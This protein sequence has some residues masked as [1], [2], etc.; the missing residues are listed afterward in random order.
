[1]DAQAMRAHNAQR[2]L[3]A[4][5]KLGTVSRAE[6]ARATRLS[7]PTVSALVERLLKAGLLEERGEGVSNGGRKP[8][9][10]GFN[11]GCG[12]VVGANIGTSSIQLAVADMNGR[13]LQKR[14]LEGISDVRPRRL[15]RRL[16]AATRR[17]LGEQ[18]KAPLFAV[19]VGAPGMTDVARGVVIEAANL[20]GWANVEVRAMLSEQL[21]APIIVDNDVNLAA[22]GEQWC[23]RARGVHNFVFIWMDAGIGAGIVIEDR[24][25]RGHRWHAGEISHINVDFRE[26]DADFGAAGYLEF[27]VGAAPRARRSSRAKAATRLGE[28]DVLRLGAAVANIAT[29]LDPEMIIFGGRL[30]A[31]APDLLPRL[32]KIA[33]R[34]AQNCPAL[35]STELGEEAALMGSVKLALERANE[36]LYEKLAQS[37]AKLDHLDRRKGTTFRATILGRA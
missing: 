27:Y 9:L 17:I 6:L 24:L 32:Q 8:Q 29:I 21:G 4:V 25:H 14:T 2:V 28:E 5:R 13:I 36:S 33:S 10:L 31:S 18:I 19:A 16:A 1:M 7:P 12:V 37:L 34:I 15:L 11:A 30:I 26:W 3:R 20:K 23:G 35:V 22:L